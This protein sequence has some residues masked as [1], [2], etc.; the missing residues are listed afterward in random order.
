MNTRI[1]L[2]TGSTDFGFTDKKGRACGYSWSIQQVT[3]V[4]PVS[5]GCGRSFEAGQPMIQ[6]W[7]GPTR[8]GQSYGPANRVIVD[9]LEEARQIAVRRAEASKKR[10]AKKFVKPEAA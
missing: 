5:Y 4:S 8:N 10:D 2:D 9:T 1:D 3:F 7:S 6:L